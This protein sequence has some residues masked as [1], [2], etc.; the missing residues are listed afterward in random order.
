MFGRIAAVAGPER[1]SITEPVRF[2][3]CAEIDE[4]SI[5]CPKGIQL[6]MISRYH[7]GV[8]TAFLHRED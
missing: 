2:G 6:D 4:C 5:L 1:R 3:S 8:L 7:R